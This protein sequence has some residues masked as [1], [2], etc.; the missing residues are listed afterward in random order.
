MNATRPRGTAPPLEAGTRIQY[1]A[2][3]GPARALAYE[4]LGILVLE[5]LLRH[6]PRTYIDAR[7][8]V[9]IG[10]LDAH[11][12]RMLNPM[13]EVVEGDVEELLHVGRLV[14]VHPLTRGLHAKSLRRAVRAALAAVAG[15]ATD[16]LPSAIAS[17]QRLMPLAEAL[18]Q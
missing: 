7:R 13:F 2:G 1:L 4:R 17:S 12:R 10:E 9:R 8:F 15:Q 6:Y 11:E 14:P 3:V 18:H 16:P 5:D